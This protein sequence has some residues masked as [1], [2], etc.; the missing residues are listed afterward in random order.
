M[1]KKDKFST[2]GLNIGYIVNCVERDYHG[3]VIGY[4]HYFAK[5]VIVKEKGLEYRDVINNGFYE[6]YDKFNE[7][8]GYFI[9]KTKP[10]NLNKDFATHD[11]LIDV[12]NLEEKKF[13]DFLNENNNKIEKNESPNKKGIKVKVKKL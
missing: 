7:D 8:K 2:S 12:I 13:I 3:C 11:E 4:D 5:C 10:L 9:F 1:S 6:R